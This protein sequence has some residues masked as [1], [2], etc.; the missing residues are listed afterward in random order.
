MIEAS[1]VLQK[2]VCVD[3]TGRKPPFATKHRASLLD[4]CLMLGGT[5]LGRVVG[6]YNREGWA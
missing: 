2:A 6:V 3:G 4:G 1:P 5:V